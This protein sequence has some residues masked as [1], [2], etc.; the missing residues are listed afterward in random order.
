[1]C[2]GRFESALTEGRVLVADGAMGTTLFSLGLEGGGCPELLNVERPD[3]V[4]DV[5]R[6]FAQAGSDIMLTNTFGG[7]ARRLTLHAASHRVR[8]LN[9][10]A[11]AVARRATDDTGALVAGSVGP[12][13]DL[14]A[15]LGALSHAQAVEVFAEQIDALVG[16]GVD[17]VWIETLSS[18]EELAAATEAAAGFDVPAVATLSFDTAGKT[19][20]GVSGSDVATWASADGSLAAIGANCGIGPGDAVAAV[21]DITSVDSA[22]VGIAKPNCGMPLYETDRLVYP[23]GADGMADFADLAIRSGARI[24]GTCCGSTPE[25]IAALRA[26]VD[27]HVPAGRPARGEIEERLAA[28]PLAAVEPQRRRRRG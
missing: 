1:M 4:A 2:T 8:E 17:V 11:V 13:G 28:R 21:F 27:R 15:P 25:H 26:A 6:R 20:M 16:A 19:M 14:L 7:N 23:I 9:E 3:L 24:L 18:I 10:A 12:T 22:A 5:H